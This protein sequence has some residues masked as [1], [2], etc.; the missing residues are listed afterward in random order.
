MKR[1]VR[2]M[3]PVFQTQ[4]SLSMAE[5]PRKTKIMVSDPLA[6]TFMAYLTVLTEFSSMFA[7]MYFWQQTP[8]KTILQ[9]KSPVH[10]T[11]PCTLYGYLS[12]IRGRNEV[13]TRGWQTGTASP[14]SG[15][16][17]I[18]G[19]IWSPAQWSWCFWCI[20]SEEK[21]TGRKPSPRGSH[22]TPPR[23][24]TLGWNTDK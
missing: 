17:G 22:R 23:R 11:T 21:S 7:L 20:W 14:Q 24:R 5:M 3:K 2:R 1:R 12:T 6:R 16:T 10:Y 4:I 18:P 9:N 15:R 8:Q 13:L 19:Q